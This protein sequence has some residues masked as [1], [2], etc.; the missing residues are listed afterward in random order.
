MVT[1]PVGLTIPVLAS[2]VAPI[3]EQPRKTSGG[4]ATSQSSLNKRISSNLQQIAIEQESLRNALQAI[5]QMVSSIQD[6]AL[7]QKSTRLTEVQLTLGVSAT[8]QVGILGVGVNVQCAASIQL[9]FA[10]A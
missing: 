6:P 1:K 3:S 9:K 8:G 5:E 4:L 2:A 7:A 10:V